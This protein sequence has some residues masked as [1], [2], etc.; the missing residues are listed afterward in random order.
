M[1]KDPFVRL[2]VTDSVTQNELYEAYKK[3]RSK[4]ESKRFAP[5]EEGEEACEK[6]DEIE[7]A[8]READEILR[9]RYYVSEEPDDTLKTV[10]EHLKCGRYA[11]A[12]RLLDD[13]D[14]HNAEWHFLYSIVCHA[15]KNESEALEHL[16]QAVNLEPTNMQYADALKKLQDYVNVRNN[17]T[18]RNNYNPYADMGNGRSY[19]DDVRPSRS[20]TPCDCCTSLLCADCCCECMGGDLITCC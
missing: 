8:Y 5:G 6:L 2:G 18:Y 9:S 4:W 16:R 3:E 12:E 7:S 17:R 11:E 13:Y 15:K 1:Q 20:V 10:D 19:R 14:D